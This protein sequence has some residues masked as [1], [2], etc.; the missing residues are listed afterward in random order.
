MP[1]LTEAARSARRQDLVDAAWRCIA[2][3]GYRDLTVDDVCA[4]AGVSK[5]A[6]YGY[7][8]RKQDL[9][10]ALLEE[11][12]VALAAALDDA[13]RADAGRADAGRGPAGTGHG[14]GQPVGVPAGAQLRRFARAMLE[15]AADPARV[16]LRADLWAAASTEPQVR[17]RLAFTAAAQRGWLREVVERGI[18]A[19]ELAPVPANALASLLLA[20]TDGL[21]LHGALNPQAFRWPN[22]QRALDVLL[23]GVE[24]QDP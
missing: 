5:G 21:V 16:Q 4:E 2:R 14:H 19:G 7:F 12:A 10:V 6:F 23:E 8:T 3:K 22:V 20:L 13:G 1:K 15:R 17:E 9:L 18:A 24:V 11:D